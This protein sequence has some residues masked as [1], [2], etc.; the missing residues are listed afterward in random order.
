MEW[1]PFFGGVLA[2]IIVLILLMIIIFYLHKRGHF[3]SYLDKY[4]DDKY[5]CTTATT[6]GPKY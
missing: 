4:L 6:Y 5:K 2:G 3:C 1:G